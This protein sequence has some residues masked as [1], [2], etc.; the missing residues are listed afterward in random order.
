MPYKIQIYLHWLA[1]SLEKNFITFREESL[2]FQACYGRIID[3]MVKYLPL[4]NFV[5]NQKSERP[6]RQEGR[7][8]DLTMYK[9]IHKS[10][11]ATEPQIHQK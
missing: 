4:P 2:C 8:H 5:R 10:P 11:E 6:K 9:T 1:E 7:T 3:F